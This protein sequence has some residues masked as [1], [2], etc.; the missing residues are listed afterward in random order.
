[1]ADDENIPHE[2][3]EA[4]II[5]MFERCPKL[6]PEFFESFCKWVAWASRQKKEIT[7]PAMTD[8]DKLFELFESSKPE[9]KEGLIAVMVEWMADHWAR[10]RENPQAREAFDNLRKK[11]VDA[12]PEQHDPSQ[13]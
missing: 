9:Y 1:M 10:I 2:F 5:E 6:I 4:V 11:I 3:E 12:R 13:W 8:P 7:D